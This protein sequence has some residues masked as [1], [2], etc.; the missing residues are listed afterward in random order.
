M[1]G[2]VMSIPDELI[3]KYYELTT[4]RF[5]HRLEEY[6]TALNS[7]EMN[8]RDA[9]FD[10]AKTLVRMYHSAD[11]AQKAAANFEKVFSKK[12]LPN[13]IKEHH[14]KAKEIGII[15]LL[16]ETGLMASR[17]EAKRKIREGAIDIDGIS[18]GNIKYIVDLQ[19]PV[20]IRAGK[21]KFLKV[22][23]K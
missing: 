6:R 13:D 17:G 10:L 3:L 15:D 2:R 18:V 21:H 5:P 23:G 20:I 1:F 7:G 14:V 9:K 8:P 12:E 4:D 19:K 11:A 22:V 16:V